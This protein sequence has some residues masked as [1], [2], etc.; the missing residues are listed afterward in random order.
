MLGDS[1]SGALV[2]VGWETFGGMKASINRN[3]TFLSQQA[4]HFSTLNP[5]PPPSLLPTPIDFLLALDPNQLLLKHQL[6][7]GSPLFSY[8]YV[9]I[10]SEHFGL[11][12]ACESS[13][14]IQVLAA[15][16]V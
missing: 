15:L 14:F 7:H 4:A 9:V 16:L 10:N 8:P 3:E 13:L 11:N 2:G 6:I 1:R 5:T 12:D